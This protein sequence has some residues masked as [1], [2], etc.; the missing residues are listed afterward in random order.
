MTPRDRKKAGKLGREF[1]LGEGGLNAENMCLQMHNSI[2]ETLTN[3]TRRE[4]YKLY[5]IR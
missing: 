4:R 2:Q 1:M 5:Q 3:W